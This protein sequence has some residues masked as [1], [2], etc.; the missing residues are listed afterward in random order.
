MIFRVQLVSSTMMAASDQFAKSSSYNPV[1]TIEPGF[2]TLYDRQNVLLA[3]ALEP[4]IEDICI[5]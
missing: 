2:L 3:Q 4:L 5:T 1:L